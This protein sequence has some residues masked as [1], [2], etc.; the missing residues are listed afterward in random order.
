MIKEMKF[1]T[2]R[3]NFVLIKLAKIKRFQNT[4]VWSKIQDENFDTLL[5]GG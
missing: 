3:F 5:V 4:R 2:M 1:K